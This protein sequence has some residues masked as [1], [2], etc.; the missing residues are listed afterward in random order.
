MPKKKS[1]EDKS[2]RFSSKKVNL[3]WA[4]KKSIEYHADHAKLMGFCQ[5]TVFQKLAARG[6]RWTLPIKKLHNSEKKNLIL[7]LFVKYSVD[8]ID[9]EIM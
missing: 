4:F 6:K 3:L 2:L 5:T 7:N 8:W 1:L 9:E